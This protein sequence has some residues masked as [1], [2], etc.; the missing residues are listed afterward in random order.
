MDAMAR[1]T[2]RV[3]DGMAPLFGLGYRAPIKRLILM[4]R[5]ADAGARVRWGFE[6][7][8]DGNYLLTLVIEF[9]TAADAAPHRA[10]LREDGWR[11]VFTKGPNEAWSRS[12][13]MNSR[14]N[15]LEAMPLSGPRVRGMLPSI[16]SHRLVVVDD[17]YL[18]AR[19]LQA[20]T[21]LCELAE[22][23]SGRAVPQ[24]V[25]LKLR[26]VVREGGAAFGAFPPVDEGDE[27]HLLDTVV[28]L[29]TLPRTGRPGGPLH[30]APR[31]IWRSDQP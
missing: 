1:R 9:P 16:G 24:R 10:A 22:A 15:L 18:E 2:P 8:D 14:A 23:Q 28:E 4:D 11:L 27:R 20:V 30:G 3:S 19:T 25:R 5:A 13:W 6:D 12:A 29:Q 7:D 26:K 17:Q 31:A 21:R